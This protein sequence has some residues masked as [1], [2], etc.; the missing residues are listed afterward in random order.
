V[1]AKR[2]QRLV[3]K[4]RGRI[5]LLL[6]LFSNSRVSFLWL[7]TRAWA[8]SR[9]VHGF[10]SSRPSH[11]SQAALTASSGTEISPRKP[12]RLVL[13]NIHSIHRGGREKLQAVARTIWAKADTTRGELARSMTH[14]MMRHLVLKGARI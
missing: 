13:P 5:I 10:L 3:G 11:P 2:W 12:Y 4:V 6:C 14:G 9:L 8:N 7:F 1:L